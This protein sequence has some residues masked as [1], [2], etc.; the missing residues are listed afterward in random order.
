MCFIFKL[1][2]H[3]LFTNSWFTILKYMYISFISWVEFTKD[4]YCFFICIFIP[5][6]Y[7][8]STKPP[9]LTCNI[10]YRIS[11]LININKTFYR[12]KGVLKNIEFNYKPLYFIF[13]VVHITLSLSFICLYAFLCPRNTSSSGCSNVCLSRIASCSSIHSI[14]ASLR[15]Y[16]VSSNGTSSWS[17]V[18]YEWWSL[19]SSPLL[20]KILSGISAF[21]LHWV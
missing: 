17:V 9:Y 6:M 7:I 8:N 1:L 3:F 16:T 10:I 19:P 2:Y 21:I 4:F 20:I 5:T 12:M 15:I 11:I 13:K 14:R 18:Q